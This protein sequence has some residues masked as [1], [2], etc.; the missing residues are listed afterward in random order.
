M[1]LKKQIDSLAVTYGLN[2][3]KT[4]ANGLWIYEFNKNT[5][6]RIFLD[7]HFLTISVIYRDC[8]G[9]IY[10]QQNISDIDI[11]KIDKT[12]INILTNVLNV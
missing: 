7:K 4:W 10:L 6:L 8:G 3:Y 12:L 9:T 5:E 11:K 2:E 1:S